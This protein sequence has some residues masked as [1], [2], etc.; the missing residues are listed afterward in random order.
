MFFKIWELSLCSCCNSRHT[1]KNPSFFSMDIYPYVSENKNRVVLR[2]CAFKQ[3][4]SR[5]FERELETNPFHNLFFVITLSLFNIDY[6]SL[7]YVLFNYYTKLNTCWATDTL[8]FTT[9][10]FLLCVKLS[11]C[12]LCDCFPFCYLRPKA[13]FSVY[14]I[15]ATFFNN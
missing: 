5:C 12:V 1:H 15:K 2:H 8:R 13:I 9:M 7:F 6:L 11:E 3:E 10:L 14:N 4:L